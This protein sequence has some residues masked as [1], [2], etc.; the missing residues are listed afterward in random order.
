LT[1]QGRSSLKFEDL[2]EPLRSE[3]VTRHPMMKETP[4]FDDP[5][6]FQTSWDSLKKALD[7]LPDR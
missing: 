7:A 3:I 6:P 4:A 2:P 5:R 1:S